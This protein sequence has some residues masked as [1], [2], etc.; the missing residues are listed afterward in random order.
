MKKIL[1]ISFLV[2]P[3]FADLSISQ[4]ETMVTKIK[5][6]RVGSN[7][8]NNSELT[9][10]FVMMHKDRNT[11]K[12]IIEDPKSDLIQFLLGGVVNDRAFV[13]EQWLSVGDK[14]SGYEVTELKGNSVTLIKDKRTIKIFLKKS[15][16]ILQ[17]NEG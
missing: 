3:L 9:S 16:Q 15:K 4:M 7:K 1:L 10:P 14:I 11:S 17:L 6:K 13:N 12:M 5:A 2:V 8:S